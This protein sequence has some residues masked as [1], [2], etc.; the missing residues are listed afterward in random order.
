MRSPSTGRR[1]NFSRAATDPGRAM[2]YAQ[3]TVQPDQ[4]AWRFR[5]PD[6]PDPAPHKP[7]IWIGPKVSEVMLQSR[8]DPVYPPEAIEA[9]VEGVVVLNVEVA[10]DGTVESV[11]LTSGPPLL[12]QPAIAA[13]TEWRYKPAF[14]GVR[15]QQDGAVLVPRQPI[16][17]VT[18]VE[19]T[20]V[21]RNRSEG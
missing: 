7:G 4:F 13:V 21:A 18:S 5:S 16:A 1:L 11:K 14:H 2:C 15:R 10:E 6:A 20:F 9:H 12:V 3:R 19:I 17:F 8:V